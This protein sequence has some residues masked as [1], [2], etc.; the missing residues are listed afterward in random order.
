[1]LAPMGGWSP[2]VIDRGAQTGELCSDR[3]AQA[4]AEFA[5]KSPENLQQNSKLVAAWRRIF[6][7]ALMARE[8]L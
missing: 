4:E 8:K 1:M 5:T 7:I 6:A 2:S 3:P